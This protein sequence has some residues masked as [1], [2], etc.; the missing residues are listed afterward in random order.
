MTDDDPVPYDTG[1]WVD[2]GSDGLW[3]PG[4]G[5]RLRALTVLGVGLG[6]L[7]LL[8]A[9]VSVGGGDDDDEEEAAPTSTAEREVVTTTSTPPTTQMDPASVAGEDPPPGC[10]EDIGRD[11]APLRER[12]ESVVLV[13][14]GTSRNGHAGSITNRLAELGYSTIIPSNASRQPVT[15]VEFTA[16]FCAESV[17]IVQDLGIATAEVRPFDPNSDVFLGRAEVLVTAGADSL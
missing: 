8:S 16:G 15:T 6:A 4:I 2:V 9:I 10:T 17:R 7:L 14:N 1:E 3:R 5:E 12:S 13:L 11:A